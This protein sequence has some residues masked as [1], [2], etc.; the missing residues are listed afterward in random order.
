MASLITYDP[1]KETPRPR[2]GSRGFSAAS[3]A[4]M[5]DPGVPTPVA[6]ELLTEL[7]AI[8]EFIQLQKSGGI[9]I[10]PAPE[11][12]ALT[13]QPADLIFNLPVPQTD[14][15]DQLNSQQQQSQEAPPPPP[16]ANQKQSKSSS[17]S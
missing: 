17:S 12:E 16:P 14:I 13:S 4:V 8:P 5:F 6:D 2:S 3:G 15:K 1:T 9:K 11:P 10:E 7:K